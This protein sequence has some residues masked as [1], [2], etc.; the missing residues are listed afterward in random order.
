M[1]HGTRETATRDLSCR[2]LPALGLPVY[3]LLTKPQPSALLDFRPF[4]RIVA[5]REIPA[6][7]TRPGRARDAAGRRICPPTSCA[8]SSTSSARAMR[9]TATSRRTSRCSSQSRRAAIRASS[10]RRSWTRCPSSDLVSKTEIAGPG[11]HQFPSVAGRLPSRSCRASS[12][13]APRTG[14]ASAAPAKARWSSSSRR[15]RP[16]R[17]TSDTDGRPRSAMRSRRC[18]SRRATKS[19]REFYYND[20]GVQIQNLALSVQAR[21]RGLKPGDAGW[22]EAAYNGEYIQDIAD[23]FLAKKSVHA[24]RRRNGQ[25][26]RQ[27]R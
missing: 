3:R 20:A 1:T 22:P 19:R 5:C 26:E 10:R 24:L 13:S 25:G 14:T 12:I 7:T 4:P 15:I 27:G 2:R 11:L 16:D 17:C 18:C 23:D 9:R 8:R 6:R 21:A